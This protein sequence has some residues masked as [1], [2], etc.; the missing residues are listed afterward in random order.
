MFPSTGSRVIDK[1]TKRHETLSC[2]E[3]DCSAMR[4]IIENLCMRCRG[5]SINFLVWKNQLHS[6][7]SNSGITDQPPSHYATLVFW[8]PL[9]ERFGIMKSV[10]QWFRT[11]SLRWNIVQRIFRYCMNC[12]LCAMHRFPFGAWYRFRRDHTTPSSWATYTTTLHPNT[13]LT[14]T[15]IEYTH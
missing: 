9:D 4:N 15:I 1:N 14:E 11:Y 3:L 13:S 5:N 6:I 2:L 8:F 7:S 12:S 10:G